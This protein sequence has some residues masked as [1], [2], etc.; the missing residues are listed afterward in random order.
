M[1]EEGQIRKCT[2]IGNGAT[3]K[4]FDFTKIDDETV[5][6]CLAYRHWERIDWWPTYYVC[7]D[8]VVLHSNH[9]DI[10]KMILVITNI[11]VFC[12]TKAWIFE[13]ISK[14]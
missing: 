8:H 11:P 9:K 10:K 3:L 1:S 5:G 14:F 2:V 13:K 12:L 4:D 7:V 6:M